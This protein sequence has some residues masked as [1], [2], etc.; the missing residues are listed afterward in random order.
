[1][2]PRQQNLPAEPSDAELWKERGNKAFAAKKYAQAKSDYT[3][4]IALQPTCLA[5]AN[6]AM[7]ELKLDEYSAAEADCTK[8]L[9]LDPTYVKAYLR[10]AS[11]AKQRGKLI[12]AAEDFEH[13]LRLEPTSKTTLAEKQTC[14][15]GICLQEGLARNPPGVTIPIGQRVSAQRQSAGT[16]TPAEDTPIST[17]GHLHTLIDQLVH[18]VSCHF[19]RTVQSNLRNQY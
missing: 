1:M 2:E 19:M 17:A 4:S 18:L 12:E 13:A 14:L 10:R 3:Q 5:Y 7:A 11:A 6:R 8:A 9:A 16:S 15:D